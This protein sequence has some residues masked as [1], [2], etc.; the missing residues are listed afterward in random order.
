V[1]T[2]LPDILRKQDL[3][4]HIWVDQVIMRSH[5]IQIV[6]LYFVCFIVRCLSDCAEQN[7][8]NGHGKCIVETSSCACFVG[9]GA[10]TDVTL[11]RAPDCTAR[12][13]PAGKSWADVPTSPTSAHALAECSNRGSCDRL[14]GICNCFPGFTG[15]ACQRSA[16]PNLCSGHGVCVSIAQMARLSYALPLGPNTFY[17]G[18]EDASTWDESMSYGCV[19]DS[20]WAVGLGPG[21]TQVPEWFGPDCSL[22]TFLTPFLSSIVASDIVD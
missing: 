10:A 22:R 6:A 21:E 3:I 9:Y 1:W 7:Y 13:C 4:V 20:S 11:Y 8:C 17:E 16:C 14:Q 15:A 5:C 19:C 18:D 2:L 12:T